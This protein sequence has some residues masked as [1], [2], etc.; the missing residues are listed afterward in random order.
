MKTM[1]VQLL[2]AALVASSPAGA[3]AANHAPDATAGGGTS[4]ETPAP[5]SSSAAPA[6]APP[7]PEA[8]AAS[9]SGETP[10]A[11]ALPEIPPSPNAPE[12][13]ASVAA[14]ETTL[15]GTSDPEVAVE[16]R[17]LDDLSLERMLNVQVRSASFF[18]LPAEKVP[19]TSYR[20]EMKAFSKL[21]VRTLAELLDA[22]IPGLFVGNDRFVGP[23][24]AHR[25]AMTDSNAKTVVMLDGQNL[26]QRFAHGYNMA[27]ALPLLGDIDTV[28]VIQGPGAILYGSGSISGFVNMLP[29]SGRT[30]PGLMFTSELGAFDVATTV[31]TS[32]GLSYGP[33]KG[34]DLFIYAGLARAGGF[35]PDGHD[36]NQDRGTDLSSDRQGGVQPSGKVTLNWHHG[37][38][39]LKAQYLDMWSTQAAGMSGNLP[40][41]WHEGY[42]S[43]RPEYTIPLTSTQELTLVGS[44]MLHES[45]FTERDGR[46]LL[47]SIPT[48][49]TLSET[50][51]RLPYTGRESNYTARLVYRLRAFARQKIAAGAE[52]ATRE[53]AGNKAWFYPVPRDLAFDSLSRW[54][55]YS[56][57]AEDVIE[58]GPLLAVAGLRYDLVDFQGG[59]FVARGAYDVM[60][61]DHVSQVSPRLSLAYQL[62]HGL[63][64]RLSYQRGFRVADAND[65]Q[66]NRRLTG[67]NNRYWTPVG[68]FGGPTW[69]APP[70]VVA[71]ETVD[72]VELNVHG[73]KTFRTFNLIG[74]VNSYYSRFDRYIVYD[75]G[76]RNAPSPFAS[77]GG[78]IVGKVQTSRGDTAQLSYAYSKPVGLDAATA[79]EIQLTNAQRSSW[80]L[81]YPH[82]IKLSGALVVPGFGRALSI[83]AAAR[84]Y[85]GLPVWNQAQALAATA[86][87]TW[88]E[89]ARSKPLIAVSASAFYEVTSRLQLKLIVE[90][91]YHNGTPVSDL[92]AGH[93]EL[94]A[95]G[96]DRRLFYLTLVAKVD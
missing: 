83:G 58:Y 22:T 37:N 28:E 73:Q 45:G 61:K 92:Y 46:Q 44:V 80:R 59:Y 8:P 81:Y 53:F 30:S 66:E 64:T 42:L 4:P 63:S 77:V 38:L 5:G 55:E 86:D 1:V 74:D 12:T 75:V 27:L 78:E 20:L 88:D 65:L 21:P 47:A 31:Q 40:T 11:G 79:Q 26:N 95:T 85:S 6:A 17:G 62:G 7:S 51:K 82:Q 90:N 18:V 76:Q 32:Y 41:G 48:T 15:G 25:G 9:P 43:L 49:S 94:T 52:F 3:T 72:S 89:T 35:V 36:W 2:M 87:P 13:P 68:Q 71:P 14:P 24:L 39:R 50:Q 93:P 67:P 33:R 34:N 57:F 96:L 29:K 16:L 19:N 54:N 91:S 70:A 69:T 23:V 56:A 10:A 60:P 84:Y